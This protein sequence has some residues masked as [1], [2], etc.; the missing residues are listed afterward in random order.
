MIGLME[1][2]LYFASLHGNIPSEFGLLKDL[3]Y[4]GMDE[5][6]IHG[7]IPTELYNMQQIK[8]LSVRLF[9]PTTQFL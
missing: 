9:Q 5:T 6:H 2:E 4:L 7:P 3:H 8:Y 1:L